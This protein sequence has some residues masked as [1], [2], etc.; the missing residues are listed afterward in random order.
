MKLIYQLQI[1]NKLVTPRQ[2]NKVTMDEILS[3]K[4]DQ[5]CNSCLMRYGGWCIWVLS[6]NGCYTSLMSGK[7]KVG[8]MKSFLIPRLDFLGC[9]ILTKMN[10]VKVMI[11]LVWSVQNVCFWTNSEISFYRT[12][13]VKKE[14]IQC[15]KS[16]VSSVRD[17]IVVSN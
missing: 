17:G 16:R 4:L 11:S 13:G 2:S 8:P 1:L 7:N 15:L 6:L 3:V 10:S 9:P 14:W 5:F 12:K